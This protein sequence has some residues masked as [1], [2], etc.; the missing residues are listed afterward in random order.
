MTDN[1][2]AA[3]EGGRMKSTKEKAIGEL[4][5]KSQWRVGKLLFTRD[6]HDPNVTWVSVVPTPW[7]RIRN[8]IFSE[9][10]ILWTMG[11]FALTVI[12]MKVYL[13]YF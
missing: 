3:P 11:G 2:K 6:S 5:Q 8:F 9:E 4:I 10:F 7:D 12:L 1:K 13:S